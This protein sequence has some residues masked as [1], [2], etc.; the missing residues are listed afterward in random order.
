MV[1]FGGTLRNKFL[2]E[3]VMDKLENE[4]F[5]VYLP[6]TIPVNDQGIAVGQ[7]AIGAHKRLML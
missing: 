4:K 1:L 6:R 3:K 7:L 2:S 5:K